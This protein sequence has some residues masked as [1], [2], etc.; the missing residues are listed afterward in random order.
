MRRISLLKRATIR[1]EQ[2]LSAVVVIVEERGT[3]SHKF[4]RDL[5]QPESVGNVLKSKQFYIRIALVGHRRK[6][7]IVQRVLLREPVGYKEIQ[8]QV[9][10]P[11][12]YRLPPPLL[13][14]HN[15]EMLSALGLM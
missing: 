9:S 11:V 6:H 4:Q 15:E 3:P 2:I 13:G 1:D 8:I 7:A 14:E 10:V 12:T 5:A